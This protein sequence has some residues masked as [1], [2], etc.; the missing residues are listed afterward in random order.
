MGYIVTRPTW[1][2]ASGFV[3][4]SDIVLLPG[5]LSGHA[6]EIGRL[7]S[8]ANPARRVLDIFSAARQPPRGQPDFRA[9]LAQILRYLLH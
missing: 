1:T 2:G 6:V 3:L 5:S 8:V 4:A 7:R 9:F